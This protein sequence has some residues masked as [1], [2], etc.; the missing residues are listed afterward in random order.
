LTSPDSG[1]AAI[2]PER[3]PPLPMQPASSL[4]KGRCVYERVHRVNGAAVV[5]G[6]HYPLIDFA[7][8]RVSF[9][10]GVYTQ[11]VMIRGAMAAIS[12]QRLNRKP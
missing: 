1:A 12:Q 5:W 6:V 9:C 8:K 4:A 10:G 3:V 7:L 2:E 11:V